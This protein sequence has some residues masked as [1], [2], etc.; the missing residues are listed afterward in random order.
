MR[1]A[2]GRAEELTTYTTGREENRIG[3]TIL[4]RLKIGVVEWW[5]IRQAAIGLGWR[6]RS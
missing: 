3:F 6:I 4:L 5:L 1:R 2:E